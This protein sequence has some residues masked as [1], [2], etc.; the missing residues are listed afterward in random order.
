MVLVDGVI[1][2]SEN[3]ISGKLPGTPISF[4][5]RQQHI[6]QS[7]RLYKQSTCLPFHTGSSE[8]N[9]HGDNAARQ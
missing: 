1:A 4:F 7:S 9:N 5:L 3:P 6:E 2:L 8:G